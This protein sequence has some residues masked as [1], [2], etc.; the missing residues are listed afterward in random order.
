MNTNDIDKLHVYEKAFEK[1][2]NL[3]FLKVSAKPR[4]SEIKLQLAE[5]FDY[6]PSKL[7]LLCWDGYPMKCMPSKFCPENLVKLKMR[8]SKLEK[9]W[10]GVQVSFENTSKSF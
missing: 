7:R 2:V 6:L 5:G 8:E 10:E 9:L 4:K 3:R 1:M